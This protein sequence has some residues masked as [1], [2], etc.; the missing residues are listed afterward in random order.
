MFCRNIYLTNYTSSQ[1]FDSGRPIGMPDS[2]AVFFL[3]NDG[4]EKPE[5]Q[6]KHLQDLL[7]SWENYDIRLVKQEG[8][9]LQDLVD[10]LD[11]LAK[12][13]VEHVREWLEANTIR[14][15]S[16]G[17]EFETLRR[18]FDKLSVAL[19]GSVRLCKLQCS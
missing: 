1:D 6:E 9:W 2:A 14:F 19:R 16:D 18:E 10:H 7:Q 8:T 4:A 17:T 13:R 12:N 3:S 11:N 15:K 5:E